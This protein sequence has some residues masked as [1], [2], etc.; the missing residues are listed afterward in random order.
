MDDTLLLT[1]VLRSN[2]PFPT[3][4]KD[5][6]IESEAFL[7]WVK[8]P[9]INPLSADEMTRLQAYVRRGTVVPRA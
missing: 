9:L 4:A 8:A 2:V 6:G 1:A 5:S 7:R 3:I